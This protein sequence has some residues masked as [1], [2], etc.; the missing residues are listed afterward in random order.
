MSKWIRLACNRI[1]SKTD[2]GVVQAAKGRIG[3]NR[4]IQFYSF[5]GEQQSEKTLSN[6]ISV[7]SGAGDVR[8]CG[9]SRGN[10][11]RL[12]GRRSFCEVE[13][14]KN[15]NYR[16]Y[17]KDD[18]VFYFWHFF[19]R[20]FNSASSADRRRGDLIFQ[21]IC[22]DFKIVFINLGGICFCADPGSIRIGRK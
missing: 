19:V 9:A 20:L 4:N 13:K 14:N 5:N 6:R 12:I 3:E 11:I 22:L 21:P 15:N 18:D 10:Q 1:R 8:C 7:R 17:Y 2:A 16:D